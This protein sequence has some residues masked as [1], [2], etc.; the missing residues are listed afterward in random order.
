MSISNVGM[1][2]TMMYSMLLLVLLLLSIDV[3]VYVYV[4]RGQLRQ[5]AEL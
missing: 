2:V 4:C 1:A 3:D 5:F